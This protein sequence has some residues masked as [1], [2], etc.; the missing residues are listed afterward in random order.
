MGRRKTGEKMTFK[1]SPLGIRIFLLATASFLSA[2][3]GLAQATYTLKAT[4][5]TAAWGYYDAKTPPV[6]RIKSS[7]TVEIHTLITSTERLE[8]SFRAQRGICF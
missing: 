8:L 1:I 3:C 2:K 7:D 4:P 6:L 5:K